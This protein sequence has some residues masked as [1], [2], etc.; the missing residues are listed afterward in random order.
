MFSFFERLI[1]PFQSYDDSRPPPASVGAFFR[2]FLRPAGKVV[3]LAAVISLLLAIL[4][5]VLVSFAGDIVD[6]LAGASPSTLWD[7][8]GTVLLAMAALLAVVRP[9]LIVMERLLMGQAFFPNMGALLRWR[10]HRHMLRQSVGFFNDDFAGRIANKQI[11]LAPAF[12]DVVFQV[13]DALWY[14]LVY[15]FAAAVVFGDLDPRLLI[16]L[17]LWFGLYCLTAWWF[18]P[19]IGKVGKE[20]AEAR[21]R[22]AGRIV[23]SYTNIQTVKLFAH[24][25]REEAYARDAMTD[26][27]N[28]FKTQT[29]LFTGLEMALTVVNTVLIGGTLGFG[30][31]L[32]SEEAITIG[33]VAAASALVLRLQ[34]MTEWIMWTLSMLFQNLGVVAEGVETVSQPL[35]LTDAKEAQ[36][37][38]LTGGAIQFENVT[39]H[40]GRD[41]TG[42]VE[43][44]DLE[45]RAGEKVGLI[46]RSGAGK[47]TLV[48]LLLRFFDPEN[49]RI[50]IDGQD[51]RHTTQSSVRQSIGMV[52]QDTSLLHRSILDNI[53]YGAADGDPTA[54]LDAAIAAAK[55]VSAHDF[56]GDLEDSEGRQ[57]NSA[58]VGERG[59]KL[60]G[61][62][63]QRIALARIV[64][65]DAPIL[66]LDEATSALDSE[67]EAAILESMDDLMA[68]KTVIA[69]AHRLSTIARMDRIVVLDEGRVIEQGSH[70]ALL[71]SGGLYAD[72]WKRQSGGFLA[73]ETAAKTEPDLAESSTS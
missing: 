17:G 3:T 29:R 58:Y 30:I 62:Q 21:S 48:N 33:T 12:N 45:I 66:V 9:L 39:H 56:I 11:Q 18:I 10:T 73:P 7:D 43:S 50:L 20:V 34:G 22:L 13:M 37:L 41:V 35:R 42:G 25:E 19:R 53:L 59:V 47:S 65:K 72:L 44:V 46:G 70:E 57:G 2:D 55:R 28:W 4:D 6:M 61:G 23:D 54:N 36:P 32:W 38:A 60:S 27:R 24:A 69:I 67:V 52:T 68:G 14:A 31:W 16:P 64:L 49:G 40:Y 1:D 8:H 71:A 26:M 15:V 63:R 5:V 51:I